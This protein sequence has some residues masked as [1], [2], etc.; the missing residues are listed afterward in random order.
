[1]DFHFHPTRWKATNT[2]NDPERAAGLASRIGSTK[3]YLLSESSSRVGKRKHEDDADENQQDFEMDE[4]LPYRANAILLKGSPISHLPTARIFAYAQHFS[5]V[6]LAL[7][8]IDDTSCV[9]VFETKTGARTGY[10]Y[11]QKSAVEAEDVEGYVTAKPVP[12][13]LWPPEERITK[14]LGKGEGLK[15]IIRMR[16]ARGED[17]KQKGSKKQSKFYEKHGTMAGKER[18]VDGYGAAKRRR[19]ADGDLAARLD[20]ELDEFLAEEDKEESPPSIMRSDLPDSKMRSDNIASDGRTL[21]QRTD[22]SDSLRSRITAPLP[23]RH[24]GSQRLW[25]EDKVDLSESRK[26]GGRTGGRRGGRT[27]RQ[28]ERPQKTQQELDD[29]LDA[30]LQE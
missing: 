6:P 17:V 5:V 22:L 4:D 15:G 8:W 29:E 20:V 7:E 27:D 11:L 13:A 18:A 24:N 3:V 14:S 28:N 10:R 25:S 2:V 16:W 12:V 23:R 19:T 9:L 30:F 1:M 21:L 26:R